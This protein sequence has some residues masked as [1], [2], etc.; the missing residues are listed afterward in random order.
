MPYRKREEQTVSQPTM[1][2]SAEIRSLKK[3]RNVTV[4]MMMRNVKKSVVIHSRFLRM[5]KCRIH[6]QESADAERTHSAGI[7]QSVNLFMVQLYTCRY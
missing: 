4:V 1:V 2:P 6:L 3:G 5:I 7:V